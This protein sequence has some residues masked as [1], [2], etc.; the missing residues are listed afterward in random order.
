MVALVGPSGAGKTTLANLVLRYFDPTGGRILFSSHD[1]ARVT[2]SS[3]RS[4][5]G[6]VTQETVLFDDTLDAN[7]SGFRPEVPHDK[8]VAAAKAAQAHDFIMQLPQGYD[9]TIGECGSLLSMGQR[10]R[11]AIAR[12][13][14]KDP[15]LLILDEATS[16]LDAESE[17]LV[18]RAL[19]T[20]LEG[21]SSLVIA[22]R[23]ATVRIASRI[24][25]MDK[26]RIVEEGTHDELIAADGL[27]ARLHEL[28]FQE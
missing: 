22:H 2:L 13:V 19:E 11:I 16:S 25:V 10:Q 26:G 23:L 7:I 27:Y 6:I 4:K 14:L 1:I 21:R 3:L 8:V 18:Q 17:S 28:Q 5:I 12:A 15:P 24:L 9:T 20:L